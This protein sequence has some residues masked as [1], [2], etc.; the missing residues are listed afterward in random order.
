MMTVEEIIKH[1]TGVPGWLN[2]EGDV[3]LL[4]KYA[5]ALLPGQTY[6]EVGTG[7]GYSA[8]VVALSAN[9]GVRIVTID[10]GRSYY[11]RGMTKEKYERKVRILLGV[12]GVADRVE[13]ICE[14]ANEVAWEKPVQI[15]FIDGD[16][17]YENVLADY[18]KWSQFIFRNG[19]LMFHDY[20]RG[21]VNGPREVVHKVIL[22]EDRWMIA[23]VGGLT[24]VLQRR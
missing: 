10:D 7:F 17:D 18:K 14:D 6:L 1:L 12:K 3:P 2:K 11:R 13:F 21:G 23:E 4:H 24:C 5:S 9:E 16:H 19:Y 15:I 8:G 22:P 20:R